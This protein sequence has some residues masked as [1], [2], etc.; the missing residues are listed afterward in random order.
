[1][2]RLAKKIAA[3]IMAL[4]LVV[5]MGTTCFGATWGSYFGASAGWYEGAEGQLTANKADGFTAKMATVGWGG[6]WG[7]QVFMDQKQNTS[8]KVSVKKGKKYT[9]TFTAKGTNVQKYVYVK[10]SEGETLAYS[11]WVKLTPGKTVK[12]NKTFKAAANAS[13]IYF[14]MGGDFGNREDTADD[15]D[16]A[17]RYA[18]FTKQFKKNGQSTLS[19]EDA[20]GDSTASI[21][22]TVSKFAVLGEA[23]IKKVKSPKKGKVKVTIA[24]ADGAAKYKVKVG[25]K[26]TTTKKTTVTVKAKA[27]KKVKVQVAPVSKSGAVGAW[28]AKKTVKVKK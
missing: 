13:T 22:I 25:S 16:A 9:L 27:G 18:A 5:A 1:M 15:V 28:S 8:G 20:N 7:A 17:I 4:T 12:V 11:T 19:A 10:I 2:R 26:T 3:S 23:K 21:D 6:I 24:K 14:G